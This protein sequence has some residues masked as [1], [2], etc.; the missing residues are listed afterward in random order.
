[1]HNQIIAK[2]A[3]STLYFSLIDR[4]IRILKLNNSEIPEEEIPSSRKD[5]ETLNSLKF[6]YLAVQYK[7]SWSQTKHHL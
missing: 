4:Q 2:M 5:Y 1:M 7:S 3:M 6:V